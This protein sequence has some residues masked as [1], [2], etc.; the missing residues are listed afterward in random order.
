MS[1]KDITSA[2]GNAAA[3]NSN[4]AGNLR[5]RKYTAGSNKN[6]EELEQ[7]VL[8]QNISKA[9]RYFDS[10][11]ELFKYRTF[12]QVNGNGTQIANK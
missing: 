11:K 5:D 9:V 10:R 8:S 3:K 6:R 7:A 1:K 4:R 2:D 12:R